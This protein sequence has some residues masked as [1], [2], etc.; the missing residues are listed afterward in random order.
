MKKLRL[1]HGT[2]ANPELL[3]KHGLLAG[4]LDR[5]EPDPIDQVYRVNKERTLERVLNEF[6]LSKHQ[7]PEWIYRGELQYEE[8]TPIHTHFELNPDNAA[9]YA[10]MGG[11]PAYCIRYN[12]LIWLAGISDRS[13]VEI[14]EQLQELKRQAKLANGPVPYV[15]EVEID[16]DDPRLEQDARDMIGRVE[17]AIAE[18]KIKRSIEE[19]WKMGAHEVRYFGDVP[20]EK[21]KSITPVEETT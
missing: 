5:T 16:F 14:R 13:C 10:D 12:L 15:V 4:G 9:G 17:Q 18:G 3:L 2:R 20:P 1:Y 21:I 19:F 8:G 6:G 7:V 11:E